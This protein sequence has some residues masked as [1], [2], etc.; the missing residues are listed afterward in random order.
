MRVRRGL[1]LIC[2]TFSHPISAAAKT[3]GAIYTRFAVVVTDDPRV[4][5][6]DGPGSLTGAIMGDWTITK[7][8]TFLC[9]TV[10]GCHNSM[11]ATSHF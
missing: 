5:K 9:N 1:S 6:R 4:M 2:V 8:L 10:R 7:F 3:I 11:R